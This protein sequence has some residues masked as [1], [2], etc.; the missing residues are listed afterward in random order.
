MI[1]TTLMADSALAVAILMLS[2]WSVSLV[3]RDVSIID[4]V[5]GVG[6]VLIA[7]VTFFQAEA[8]HRDLFTSSLTSLWG[9]RLSLHLAWRNLGKPEDRRY[10][11]MRDRSGKWFPLSSLLTVFALQGV[12]M[13]CVAL[14]LMSAQSSTPGIRLCS[15]LGTVVFVIGLLFEA[16]AD[17]QLLRFKANPGHSGK[18]LNQGLWRF[19]RHPNYFGEILVWWGLYLVS[20]GGGSAGWT[21]L[22]PILMTFLLMKVSGV[23]LLE[24][25]LAQEKPEYEQYR[26]TTNA[27]VPWFPKQQRR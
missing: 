3:V 24:R 16:V 26:A 27:L 11:A 12:V 1:T 13:W 22:S 10:R 19:S 8:S 23:T 21:V 25:S 14:P 15:I 18:L 6:F 17:W 5:W 20:L 7:W 2:V 9:I 4:L